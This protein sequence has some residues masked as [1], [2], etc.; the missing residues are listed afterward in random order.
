MPGFLGLPAP[1]PPHLL[2]QAR[3]LDPS[4]TLVN[5]RDSLPLL[6]DRGIEFTPPQGGERNAPTADPAPSQEPSAAPQIKGEAQEIQIDPALRIRFQRQTFDVQNQIGRY[7]GG[8]TLYYDLTTLH[9]EEVEIRFLEK[10]GTAKGNIRIEDPEGY[11][12]ATELEFDWEQRTGR[13]QNVRIVT[14]GM[15]GTIGELLITPDRWTL[16]DVYGTPSGRK[17]P[18]VAVRSRQVVLRPGKNGRVRGLGIE[19]FGQRIAN[20]PPYSFTLDRRVEGFR[21][22]NI[23]FR[24]KEGTGLSWN[25]G[26]LLNDRT[27]ISGGFNAFPKSLLSGSFVLAHSDLPPRPSAGFLQPRNENEERQS[28]GWMNRIYVRTPQE[29]SDSMRQDRRTYALSSSWNTGTVGR[30]DDSFEITKPLD[31]ALELGGNRGGWGLQSQVRLHRIR[32]DNSEPFYNRLLAQVAVHSPTY[33]LGTWGR[34]TLRADLF[35]TTSDRRGFGWARA[36]AVVYRDF[37]ADF[38]LG[39]AGV[40]A[41]ELGRAFLSI[42]RPF[43][44]KA[45]HVRADGRL[46]NIKMAMMLKYDFDRRQWYDTEYSL[47]FPAGSFEPYLEARLQP[48]EFRLG[49]RLRV[50]EFFNRLS[51]RELKREPETVRFS[52]KNGDPRP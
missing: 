13:A 22:P 31:L 36:E 29:E 12:E 9:A 45:F 23:T 1:L 11:L 34:S 33:S 38:R 14:T 5:S 2:A 46:G 10:K 8:V 17:R 3:R 18:D 26:F 44:R 40:A 49:F 27:S 4:H 41:K 7:Y 52:E 19:L 32:T 16:N 47:N 51:S 30:L 39:V 50:E 37:G 48:R 6:E 21:F 35:G 15:R 43:S 28:E 42:D 25:S 20:L 24:R